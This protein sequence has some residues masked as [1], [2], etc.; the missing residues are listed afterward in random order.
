MYVHEKDYPRPQLVREDWTDL[1]GT[2]ELVFDDE[3]V[4]EKERWQEAFPQGEKILVPFTYE[5]EKSGIGRQEPHSRIWYRRSFFWKKQSEKRCIL[6][7]EGC[8]FYTKVWVN[9]RLA[10]DHKGGYARFSFDVTDLI[11]QGENQ[12]VI[13]AE[14]S[15]DISQPRGK[16]RW[17]NENFG[18]WYVQTTGIWKTVW[19]EE[20]PRLYIRTLKIT[21]FLGEGTV[22]I[23]WE[24]AGDLPWEDRKKS[25]GQGKKEMEDL[26]VLT[27][28]AE[29]QG[30][31]ISCQKLWVRGDRGR[32]VLE[33]FCR[34]DDFGEW[35]IMEWGPDSPNL[36]DLSVNLDFSMGT[37][38]VSSYFGMREIRI[39][40][41]N[42]LLNGRPLYQRLILDQGYWKE[43]HLTP[44][45]EEAL[46][47]DIDKIQRMG[48]NGVRKHQKT[49]D[50]R[51]LYWC[52]KKGLLVWSEMGAAYEFSDHGV[53][54]FTREWMEIVRQNYSHPCIITWTP[55]NESWGL[56]QIKTD[57]R[58]QH[59]TEAVYYLTK[60]FDPYRPVVVNDGW[61]HTVSDILT[62]HDYEEEGEILLERY[63]KCKE[64]IL[65][66][67]VYHCS[68]KSAFA[69]G[70]R[71]KGQPVIISEFGG[72]AFD[73]KGEGWG[74]GN[75]V[76]DKAAFIRRF[77]SITTA[78]KSL[79]Y[80][81]GYCYTQV[82]DVQ[83]E[84]NGLL[85]EDRNFKIEPEVIREINQRK[86]GYW[87]SYM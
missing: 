30:R 13:K 85:D 39:D 28:Q 87:R 16:Q 77:D 52:D 63:S 81:C 50:E 60:S 70:Y 7:L 38:H 64:E 25:G 18:C 82:S 37:D 6:H 2:W 68:S 65:D 26:P 61:E 40:G 3:N 10:G 62:L 42:I 43:S 49:E 67:Q 4:G 74:Y 20:V 11:E 31:L 72:I 8:D 54:E 12:L 15:F 86:V 14:D 17:R 75:K 84:I 19:I 58:Q 22:E 51:F 66:S 44:P 47:E 71:Y 1:N 41:Q 48:Y 34:D 80:V 55:F 56:G 83:Q 76:A 32:A 29:F 57:Q 69:K 21:P 79:P 73:G 36:Y 24:L 27:L 5:T 45:D 59:F 9:G 46:K 35:G 78:V 33:V 53:E 23:Q